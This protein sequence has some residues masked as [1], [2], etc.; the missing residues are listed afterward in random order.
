MN[1]ILWMQSCKAHDEQEER[2]VI[3]LQPL[4]L[5]VTAASLPLNQPSTLPLR[6][7]HFTIFSKKAFSSYI[8]KATALWQGFK[9]DDAEDWTMLPT[10]I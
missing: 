6:W 7:N 10:L 3:H 9:V 4:T 5:P 2:G 1:V 8:A